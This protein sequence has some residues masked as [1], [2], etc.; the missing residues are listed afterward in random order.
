MSGH[1]YE[2][3]TVGTDAEYGFPDVWHVQFYDYTGT[4]S[5]FRSE[6]KSKEKAIEYGEDRIREVRYRPVLGYAATAIKK[7]DGWY[8]EWRDNN[9]RIY[10]VDGP[11]DS[12]VDVWKY[13]TR[14]KE[15]YNP[16]IRS[17][18]AQN[19]S[20]DL[21]PIFSDSSA[22][23]TTTNQNSIYTR[24]YPHG[25]SIETFDEKWRKGLE[26]FLPEGN[27]VEP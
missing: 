4:K 22:P 10:F 7:E 11:Y 8:S 24:S 5:M 6:Y 25:R 26:K 13:W 20:S 18:P 9:N 19:S 27:Y 23:T 2:Y 14:Y 21:N 17:T 1:K 12:N 3:F 15:R 16:T